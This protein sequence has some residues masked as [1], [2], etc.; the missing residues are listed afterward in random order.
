LRKIIV[1]VTGTPGTGKSTFAREL[2]EKVKASAVIEINDVVKRRRLYSRTDR[3]GSRI[4]NIKRLD[5]AMVEEIGK[6]DK[7]VVVVVGHL[8]PELHMHP[9]MIIVLG[10]AWLSY[11]N[12]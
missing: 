10:P 4:V 5:A 11:Q 9:N 8:V 3:F 6:V 12:G 7:G 1:A 2:A